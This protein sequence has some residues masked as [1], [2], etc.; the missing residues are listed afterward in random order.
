MRGSGGDE[1]GTSTHHTVADIVAS[2]LVW[3]PPTRW[4]EE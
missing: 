1:D 2:E 4:A 3:V